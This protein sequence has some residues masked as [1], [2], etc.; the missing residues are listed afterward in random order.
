[1]FD[2][3]GYLLLL[4]LHLDYTAIPKRSLFFLGDKIGYSFVPKL[5]CVLCKG[6]KDPQLVLDNRVTEGSEK[7]S[8]MSPKANLTLITSLCLLEK[9]TPPP[10]SLYVGLMWF[11]VLL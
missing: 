2:E 9:E 10:P 11:P 6:V 5:T 3:N 4:I 8:G 7:T 1:M